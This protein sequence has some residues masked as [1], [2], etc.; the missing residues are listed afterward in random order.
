MIILDY[1]RYRIKYSKQGGVLTFDQ[2]KIVVGSDERSIDQVFKNLGKIFP[3]AS[4]ENYH[5]KVKEMDRIRTV[6]SIP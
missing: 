2:F 5:K 3:G 4:E 1:I 6:I